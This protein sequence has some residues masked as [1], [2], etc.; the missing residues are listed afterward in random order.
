M[1]WFPAD[2][3]IITT[4]SSETA[5]QLGI[6][7]AIQSMIEFAD[8]DV[9]INDWSILDQSSQAAPYVI[10][11]NADNFRSMQITQ[12]P[13][14][15]WDIPITLIERFID[16][17]TSLNNFRDRRQAIIDK[18]NSG[19]ERSANG[20]SGVTIDEIRSD[21]SIGQ[22]FLAYLTPEQ[23]VEALPTF[24]SQRIVLVTKEF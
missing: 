18:I 22:I 15:T 6:K 4:A 16:W 1:A 11:E 3:L 10:I 7:T 5:I 2:D 24:L 12:T 13:E 14:N 21:G 9:V 17:T 20:L 23:Q 8:A 19:D